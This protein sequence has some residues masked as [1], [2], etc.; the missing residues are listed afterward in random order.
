MGVNVRL[1][2]QPRPPLQPLE[3]W[4]PFF[5]TQVSPLGLELWLYHPGNV[6]VT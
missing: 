6:S 3:L 4:R 2:P 5:Y 1:A